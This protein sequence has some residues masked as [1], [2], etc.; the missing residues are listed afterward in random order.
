[1]SH[2][3]PDATTRC[4][5]SVMKLDMRRVSGLYDEMIRILSRPW[6]SCACTNAGSN[7]MQQQSSSS[8]PGFIA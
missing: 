1:M 6:V 5:K 2:G 4:S 3:T 7:W 8:Q